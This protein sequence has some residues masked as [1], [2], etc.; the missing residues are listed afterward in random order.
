MTL[1]GGEGGREIAERWDRIFRCLAAEPR[2]QVIWSLL[3]TAPGEPVALPEAT[4]DPKSQEDLDSLRVELCHLHLP[5]MAEMGFVEW[6]TDPL[7]ATHGPRFEEV[8]ALFE[9]A[10][11]NVEELPDQLVEGCHRLETERQPPSG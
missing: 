7:T 10:L 9:A 3:D 11:A 4:I 6:E 1:D 8:R 2:R 5:L